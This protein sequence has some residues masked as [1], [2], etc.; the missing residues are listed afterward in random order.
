M[1]T[2]PPIIV[3]G[4]EEEYNVLRDQSVEL[5][6]YADS[7]P[8][9]TIT[10]EKDGHPISPNTPNYF[11]S[12]HKLEILRARVSDSGNFVCVAENYV[13]S[14]NHTMRVNVHGKLHVCSLCMLCV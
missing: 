4:G 8:P 7:Y 3:Q 9:P 11:I 6:C 1:Y 2:D 10:W 14:V 13:G 5:L 12:R